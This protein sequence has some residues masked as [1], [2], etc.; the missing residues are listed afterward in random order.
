MFYEY[1]NKYSSK[2]Y[3]QLLHSLLL[4][5]QENEKKNC[6]RGEKSQR[7]IL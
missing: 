1:P 4:F 6:L 7:R 2:V 5:K 3:D